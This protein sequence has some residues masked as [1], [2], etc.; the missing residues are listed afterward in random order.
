MTDSNNIEETSVYSSS[1]PETD[2]IEGGMACGE[3]ISNIIEP[4]PSVSPEN[5]TV[6][7]ITEVDNSSLQSGEGTKSA[8]QEEETEA[9]SKTETVQS[10][11]VPKENIQPESVSDIENLFTLF[12][13]HKKCASEG[14]QGSLSF[15]L[16]YT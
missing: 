6:Q 4:E 9:V 2:G 11:E 15:Y 1:A 13:K 7:G 10:S 3:D 14:K 16:D 8:M 12:E 5:A